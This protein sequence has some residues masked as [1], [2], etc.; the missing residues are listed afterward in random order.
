[1]LIMMQWNNVAVGDMIVEV[2]PKRWPSAQSSSALSRDCRLFINLVYDN[3][4]SVSVLGS[5]HK[6]FSEQF[7]MWVSSV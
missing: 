7:E 4:Y 1:M 3:G 5:G 6:I 2:A